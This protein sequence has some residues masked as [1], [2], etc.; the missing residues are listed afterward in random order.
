MAG[1]AFGKL[2]LDEGHL[3]AGHHLLDETPAKGGEKL[4]M[5]AEMAR[6]EHRCADRQIGLGKADAFIDGARGVA[7]LEPQI[8]QQIEHVFDHLLGVGGLLVGRQ[9]QEIDVR[10]GRQL[11]TAVAA[12][13]DDGE[14][15]ALR[16]IGERIEPLGREVVEHMDELI[17]GVSVRGVG[18][19]PGGT[20]VEP[21]RHLLASIVQRPFQQAQHLGAP[22]LGR[23][24]RL[25]GL[26]D[27]GA[28][29]LAVDDGAFVVDGFHGLSDATSVGQMLPRSGRCYLGRADAASVGRLQPRLRA[30]CPSSCDSFYNMGQ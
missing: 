11:A 27:L 4:L 5:A 22:A 10:M 18:L 26:T 15:L 7:H 14:K 17:D 25:G 9:E 2:L 28:E 3:R 8:P 16:R 24:V 1:V 19:R 30:R 20:V 21:L 12:D 6:F 23:A 13:G 29:R